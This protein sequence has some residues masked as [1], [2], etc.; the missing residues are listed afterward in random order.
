[1]KIKN[2]VAKVIFFLKNNFFNYKKELVEII[3]PK[4]IKYT[5]WITILLFLAVAALQS[6]YQHYTYYSNNL[7]LGLYNQLAYKFAHFYRPSSTLWNDDYELKNCFGDHFTVL[8][9][10]NSQL[11]WIFGSYALLVAQIIYC[12]IGAFGIFKLI[13]YK[14]QNSLLALIGVLLF[15]THYSLYSAIVFDSHDNIYGIMFIPWIFYFY[16]KNNY[17]AFA[18]TLI[19]FLL[20]REDLAITGIFISISLLIFDWKKSKRKYALTML[21]ACVGYF[22]IVFYI[23][24]PPLFSL[25]WGYSP[26]RFHSLGNSIPDM[27]KKI[28]TEPLYVLG[29]LTDTVEKQQKIKYFLMTGGILCFI[30]PRFI[31]F[32]LPTIAITCLS[33]DWAFWGNM[34]HYNIIFAVLLP[35]LIILIAS[36]I[37]LKL[38]R[39]VF[40]TVYMF[41]FIHYLNKNYFHDW[42]TFPR[43]FTSNYYHRRDNLSEIKEALNIIPGSASVSAINHLTPHLAFRNKVFCYPNVKDAEYIAINEEDMA[44][45]FFPFLSSEEFMTS[46]QKLKENKDYSL[47]FDKNKM[48]LFHRNK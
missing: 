7:D 24:M 30:Q 21:L 11:Y 36:G 27:F 29:I 26:W 20:A 9:P 23:I 47:V 32:F 42:S 44:S 45:D 31:F 37:R 46:I 22:L 13:E 41:L 2:N 16:Y 3:T 38:I 4:P 33:D 14:C 43:I 40:L 48:L 12:V 10:L 5:L 17:K 25:P 35:F 15:F 1:M 6:L 34:Y 39:Y 18:I 28:I 19:P 8:M